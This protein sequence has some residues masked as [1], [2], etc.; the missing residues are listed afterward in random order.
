V[1]KEEIPYLQDVGTKIS[2]AGIER[3]RLHKGDIKAIPIL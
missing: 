3:A 1:V 2:G